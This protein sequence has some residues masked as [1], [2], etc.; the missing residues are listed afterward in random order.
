MTQNSRGDAKLSQGKE[1]LFHSMK[2]GSGRIRVFF[3]ASAGV[4]ATQKVRHQV[5]LVEKG[6]GAKS[7]ASY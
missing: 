6:D 2:D 5:H 7:R 1:G 4:D 3:G